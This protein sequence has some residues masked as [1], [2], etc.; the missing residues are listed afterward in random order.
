M[1]VDIPRPVGNALGENI[2]S[3]VLGYGGSMKAAT[4][5]PWKNQM[6]EQ[7]QV[8]LV[9]EQEIEDTLSKY[10]AKFWR[11]RAYLC[12]KARRKAVLNFKSLCVSLTLGEPKKGT[13][14]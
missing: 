4:R 13:R 12:H 2:G 10:S 11:Q 14:R 5:N 6:E 3:M 8:V 7:D 1:E 9:L